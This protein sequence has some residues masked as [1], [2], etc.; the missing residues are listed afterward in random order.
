MIPKPLIPVSDAAGVVVDA[1]LNVARF[2]TGD[3]V[4]SH[5]YSKW[6]DG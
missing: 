5:L 2:K 4:T 3:R 1:G 6:I